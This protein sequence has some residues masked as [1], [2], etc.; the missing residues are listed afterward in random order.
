MADTI[1][2][3]T[4]ANRNKSSKNRSIEGLAAFM[5]WSS[6]LLFRDSLCY[7]CTTVA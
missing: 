6:G 2:P 1:S 5:Q 7:R 4:P 3:A